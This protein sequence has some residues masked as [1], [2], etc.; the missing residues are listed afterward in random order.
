MHLNA[1]L[2]AIVISIIHFILQFGQ[3]PGNGFRV[4]QTSLDGQDIELT[5]T[6]LEL[7]GKPWYDES[8]RA[9][10]AVDGN[11]CNRHY[12]DNFTPLTVAFYDSGVILL[13]C[14]YQRGSEHYINFRIQVPRSYSSRIRGFMGNFDSDQSNEFHERGSNT[15]REDVFGNG[16]G[17]LLTLLNT[18]EDIFCA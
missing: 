15:P 13:A 1:L 16:N 6:L 17:A 4:F 9:M 10:L 18:C 3:G 2:A 8:G 5:D 12:T 14:V 11:N 7:N